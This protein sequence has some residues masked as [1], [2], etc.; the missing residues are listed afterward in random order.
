MHPVW[1]Q[2]GDMTVGPAIGRTLCV[3]ADRAH[4]A[5]LA[6]GRTLQVAADPAVV[7]CLLLTHV[8]MTPKSS[9]Y[10]CSVYSALAF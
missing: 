5:G 6:I 3:A 4:G 9:V 10:T 8:Q 1:L 7:S 2:M